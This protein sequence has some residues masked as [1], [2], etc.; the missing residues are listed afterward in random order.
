MSRMCVC[1]AELDIRMKFN[2]LMKGEYHHFWTCCVACA[3]VVPAFETVWCKGLK[4]EDC[5]DY[6]IVSLWERIVHS[7]SSHTLIGRSRQR[8]TCWAICGE[9]STSKLCRTTT[10]APSCP[11][12]RLW[13][14]S[15]GLHFL[16]VCLSVFLSLPL[17]LSLSL[18]NTRN[19]LVNVTSTGPSLV[20]L[21]F[22]L[23]NLSVSTVASLFACHSQRKQS[24]L[25]P[26]LLS[27]LLSILFSMHLLVVPKNVVRCSSFPA[28]SDVGPCQ[29]VTSVREPTSGISFSRIVDLP[30]FPLPRF[31]FPLP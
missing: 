31:C 3:R 20:W 21:T 28:S 15:L 5:S 27:V 16:S 12:K 18:M 22:L 19:M 6:I 23:T 8:C 13:V 9:R 26:A 2:S 25:L 29:W 10:P 7:I 14:A 24:M 4:L 1:S 17:S 11:R 30:C